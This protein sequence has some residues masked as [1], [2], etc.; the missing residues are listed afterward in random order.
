MLRI[1]TL[2]LNGIRSASKKGVYPWLLAQNADIVCLQE[3]RADLSD[4]SAEMLRP[5]GY[6]GYF[7]L[8]QKKGYSGVGI[9]SRIEPDAVQEGIGIADIDHEGR[10]LRLD[11]ARLSV[12]SIYFPS[13]SSS[14]ERQAVKYSFLDRILPHLLELQQSGREVL[15][16][17]DVN[18]AHR[19]IDLKNWRG[20]LQ[21]SGFLPE[22][23]SWL[24][25]LFENYVDVYRRVNPDKAEYTWW[26]NRGRARENNVGWRID[27]QMATPQ[28][29]S[30]AKNTGIYRGQS[31]SDHAPL[32]VDYDLTW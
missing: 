23:R 31:F 30:L 22:E 32:T 19:E 11:F 5:E 28:L 18:I 27:Y 3:V 24:D 2:N 16:C 13:G 14:P 7:H 9:Y 29:A 4:M 6:H 1:I 8:A 21:N 25:G 15:L 26:S 17:G 20:N 10:Y 12:A